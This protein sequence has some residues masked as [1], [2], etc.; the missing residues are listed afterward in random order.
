MVSTPVLSIVVS[1][2]IKRFINGDTIVATGQRFIGNNMF[3]Y[4]FNNPVN[5]FDT[6]GNWP[7]W[8]EDVA[9][10]LNEN[11]IEPI[12]EFAEDIAE[13]IDNYDPNNES[14]EKVL[15]SNYF[16]S[17]KGV[18]VIRTNGDR[19]G[20]FGVIY[21]TR[22]TNDRE[23]PEDVVRHEYGHTKQFEQLGIIKFALCIGIPSWQE[24]GTGEYY[25]KPWEITAEIYGDV[26]SRNHSQSDIDRGYAYLEDSKK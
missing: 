11:I 24:W 25:S 21:L 14:E 20:S 7:Q 18:P 16:S 12:K 10:W 15:K 19:S 9:D 3:A 22:E 17:Y 13:D 2:K 5:M 8:I 26:Q 6:T 1:G 23:N 4:C